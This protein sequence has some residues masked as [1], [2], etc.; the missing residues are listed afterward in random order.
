MNAESAEPAEK[1]GR[2]ARRRARAPPSRYNG[3]CED[4]PACSAG[5]QQRAKKNRIREPERGGHVG[6]SVPPLAQ[7]HG[8]KVE[9]GERSDED[10]IP[11]PVQTG[12]WFH[13]GLN[14]AKGTRK[15]S[16]F[17]TRSRLSARGQSGQRWRSL[18]HRRT[19]AEGESSVPCRRL[20]QRSSTNDRRSRRSTLAVP[21]GRRQGVRR[22]RRSRWLQ[23]SCECRSA[24][25][26]MKSP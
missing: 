23:L 16:S 18:T 15:V 14:R 24:T 20:V 10:R 21:R 2:R 26:R 17:G 5:Q 7:P 9:C 25:P 12:Y 4:P 22:A 11:T 8:K 19:V 3:D 6:G 1:P 13:F